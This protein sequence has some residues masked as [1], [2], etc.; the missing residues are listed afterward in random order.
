VVDLA[1]EIAGESEFYRKER[2]LFLHFNEERS[3]RSVFHGILSYLRLAA[4]RTA[5]LLESNR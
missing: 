4:F 2:S 1:M 3:D 5:I